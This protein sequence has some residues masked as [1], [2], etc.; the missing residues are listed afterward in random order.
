MGGHTGTPHSRQVPGPEAGNEEKSD[1]AERGFPEKRNKAGTEAAGLRP[2]QRRAAPGWQQGLKPRGEGDGHPGTRWVARTGWAGGVTPAVKPKAGLLSGSV[3]VAMTRPAGRGG[4]GHAGTRR[5]FGVMGGV[6]LGG[7]DGAWRGPQWLEGHD[8]GQRGHPVSLSCPSGPGG[9]AGGR[10]PERMLTNQGGVENPNPEGIWG[11]GRAPSRSALCD[12]P[13]QQRGA[14]LHSRRR[15]KVIT[16]ARNRVGQVPA[17]SHQ[18]SDGAGAPGAS[19][20]PWAGPQTSDSPSALSWA[21]LPLSGWDPVAHPG[22][23]GSLDR[24]LSWVRLDISPPTPSPRLDPAC[25][26]SGGTGPSALPRSAARHPN[27]RAFSWPRTHSA[28]AVAPLMPKATGM[29]SREGARAPGTAGSCIPGPAAAATATAAAGT[30]GL[31]PRKQ[32]APLKRQ[33]RS[34]GRSGGPGGGGQ[35][36]AEHAWLRTR[37][38]VGLHARGLP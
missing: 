37:V 3:R 18:G 32:A 15:L 5:W 28:K 23:D 11:F 34:G 17:R 4:I 33:R 10:Q 9:C 1:E 31:W 26:T 8:H 29:A 36:A 16:A 30:H 14:V 38:R 25:R 2:A 21:P 24:A 7:G 6:T 20:P 13:E 22:W 19:P 12:E 35:A 27:P